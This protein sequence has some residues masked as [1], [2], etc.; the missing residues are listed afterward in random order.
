MEYVM[1]L[2][3]LTK[4]FG[5]KTAVDNFSLKIEKGH[6]CGLIGPNGAGKTTIMRMMA[7][8]TE[9]DSGEMKF[10]G[11]ANLDEARSRMSF[12][13]EEPY[14]EHSMT[15]RENM[16][17][18]RFIRGVADE[19]RI[20]MLLDFVGL[21]D[22]GK[23]KVGKF[24]LGMRQRLGIAMSLLAK[25]EFMVLDEPIN[26]LDPEGII[27]VRKMLL[28]LTEEEKITIL[29]SSHILK[30]LSELC[31]DYAIV[32]HGKLIEKLSHEEL[33]AK[34]KTFIGLRTNDIGRTCTV[35]EGSLG[36]RNYKVSP[37]NEIMIY[38]RLE[39]L[40][41]ISSIVTQN[42][43]TI[44]KINVEGESLEDYYIGKVGD[45]NE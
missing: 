25:P 37:E 41:R 44:T 3:G 32:N 28:K 18:L 7:S 17:Y 26:G 21:K 10:F 1:E 4:T 12:I 27:D 8:L 11:S 34:T 19:S 14:M 29:I 9:P 36:I 42:N 33:L 30:E 16:Q 23:K 43:L 40:E 24:S 38:E 20:D 6:I 45:Q 15:A 2:E 31:T 35:L 13:I 5:K 22:V 39:D